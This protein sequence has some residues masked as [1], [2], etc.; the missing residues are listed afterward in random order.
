MPRIA[1]ASGPS[2][3]DSSISR[4]L[5]AGL[6]VIAAVAF[7][8]TVLL[9]IVHLGDR[10]YI[11]PPSG[12]WM[13]LADY[14]RHGVV[15]PAITDGDYFAG[16]RYMPLPV[17]LHAGLASIT[18]EYLSSGK[19][20]GLL[21]MGVLCLVVFVVLRRSGLGRAL[22]FGLIAAILAGHVGSI[23]ALSIRPEAVAATLALAALAVA[24]TGRGRGAIVLAAILCSLAFAAKFSAVYPILAIGLWLLLLDRQRFSSSRWP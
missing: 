2:P 8:A 4:A 13:G 11:F 17:L 5:K 1:A 22:T 12:V 23:A 14:A 24:D 20:L 21:S 9:A 16:T 18:G 15:F 19:L 7:G 10:Y 3:A 6:I